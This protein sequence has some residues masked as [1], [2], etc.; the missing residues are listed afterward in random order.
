MA[1]MATSGDVVLNF[2][3]Q[4]VKNVVFPKVQHGITNILTDRN[5]NIKVILAIK[6]LCVFDILEI[7]PLTEPFSAEQ[8]RIV[9]L[10]KLIQNRFEDS[11]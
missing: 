3:G 5:I 11:L 1:P 8:E 7:D 9:Q 4:D 2:L 6:T 10:L